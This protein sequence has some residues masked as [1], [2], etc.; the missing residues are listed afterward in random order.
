MMFVS[1]TAIQRR[2][3]SPCPFAAAAGRAVLV[4]AC[5]ASTATTDRPAAVLA[6]GGGGS[7]APV[8]GGKGSFRIKLLVMEVERAVPP[9]EYT[10][11]IHHHYCKRTCFPYREEGT[12]PAEGALGSGTRA[13]P[14]RR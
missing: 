5:T 9:A 3:D 12:G 2:R 13:G 14:V 11:T 6:A 1:F 4:C 10:R 7:H 8:V